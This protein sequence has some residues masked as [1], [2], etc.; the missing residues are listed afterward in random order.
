MDDPLLSASRWLFRVP[1]FAMFSVFSSARK[2]RVYQAVTK[3]KKNFPSKMETIG[4][5]EADG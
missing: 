5:R 1:V 2:F 3:G 4:V